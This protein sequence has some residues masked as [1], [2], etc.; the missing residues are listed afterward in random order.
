MGS[1]GVALVSVA[2][3]AVVTLLVVDTDLGAAGRERE[4]STARVILATLHS[5]YAA[6]GAWRASSLTPVGE[7]ARSTGLGLELVTAGHSLLD[8]ASAGTAGAS[9]AFP[10]VVDGHRVGTAIVSFPVSG[11][12]SEEVR[13]RHAIA[14]AVLAASAM[15]A[16]VALTAAAIASRRLVAPVRSLTEAARRLGAGDLGSRVGQVVA[17][18]EIDE[19]AR[20]FDG[21]AAH[22]Q[23]ADASRRAIVAD[24]AHELRTPLAVLR[25][26]LEALELG[27]E[28]LTP[29][30]VSSLDDEVRRL[31]RL[32]E[33][34]QVLAAAEAAGLSLRREDVDLAAIA[35]EAAGRVGALFAERAVELTTELAPTTIVADA[36]RVEQMVVNLL[37]NA[38][39]FTPAGGRVALT[40]ERDQQTARVA[41]SDTG[42]GI[43]PEEQGR[44]FER[45]F[46]GEAA[47]GVPGSGV[48]LAVVSELAA[49]HGGSVDVES[50]PGA[51]TTVT[52]SFPFPGAPWTPR[53]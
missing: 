47:H 21:M 6:R 43:P 34:L 9:K 8:V 3:L 42:V 26:E 31:S 4:L 53:T 35:V 32:V 30:A 27:V 17:P 46:R 16:L 20:T 44:V 23:R 5:T 11:L 25:A 18:R 38:A 33:D 49:A 28:E 12:T 22:L 48:G 10:I 1:L 15:A 19:L 45:F 7:L 2:L 29:A 41:V 37:S 52:V 14:V 39:K 51:G 40:V 24:L 36:G 50:T 13:L